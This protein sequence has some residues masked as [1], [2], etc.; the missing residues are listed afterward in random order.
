M[1]LLAYYILQVNLDMKMNW[2]IISAGK[3]QPNADEEIEL[4]G[5]EIISKVWQE[6]PPA[7]HISVFVRLST[8]K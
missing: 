7:D 2:D 6:N 3:Y 8:G 4:W 1:T 5:Y